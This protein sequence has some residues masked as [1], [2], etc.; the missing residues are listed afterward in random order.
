MRFPT[1]RR[2]FFRFLGYG[3]LLVGGIAGVQLSPTIESV[4][5]AWQVVVIG[6]ALAGGAAC[7]AVGRLL[8]RDRPQQFGLMTLAFALFWIFTILILS[9][10]AGTLLFASISWALACFLIDRAIQIDTDARE[11]IALEQRL[12]PNGEGES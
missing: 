7:T 9:A 2:G 8:G 6:I 10:N 4:A 11:R 5:L 1:V 12:R 3:G